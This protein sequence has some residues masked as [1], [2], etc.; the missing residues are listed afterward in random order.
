M[1]IKP[2]IIHLIEGDTID[3][4]L[5]IPTDNGYCHII[6]DDGE[7]R[8]NYELVWLNHYKRIKSN[9]SE[10]EVLVWRLKHGV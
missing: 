3:I 6:W 10:Q 9:L 5:V 8:K 1:D 4:G 7:V 2:F